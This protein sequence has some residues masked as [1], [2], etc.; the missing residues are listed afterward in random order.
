MSHAL[1]RP[2]HRR[3]EGHPAQRPGR[4]LRRRD[5]RRAHLLLAARHRHRRGHRQAARL[6]RP[7]DLRR[8]P[9]HRLPARALRVRAREHLAAVRVERAA[10]LPVLQLGAVEPALRQ[11]EGAARLRAAARRRGLAGLRAGGADGV[12]PLRRAVGA[13]QGRRLGDPEGAALPAADQQ[14]RAPQGGR[15][16]GREE[17][18]RDRPLRHS[19][20]APSPRWCTPC[21]GWCCTGCTGC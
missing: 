20:R 11:A 1:A 10:R 2:R 4:A 19:D 17:G 21:R 3:P 8:R 12:G 16:R 14:R 6:D 5:R 9:P 15:A 7:A 13:A 18:D